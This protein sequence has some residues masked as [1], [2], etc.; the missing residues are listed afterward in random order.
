MATTTQS[1]TATLPPRITTALIDRLTGMVTAGA[2]GEKREPYEMIE[3]Y[4]GKVVGELPQSSPEDVAAAAANARAAQ[5]EWASWPLRRRLAVFERAHELILSEQETIADLIQIGSGKTRRMASEESCD[6]PMVISHYLKTA[7]RV[8]KPVRRGGPMPIISTSIEQHR[9]KGVVAVISPWNFP[10]AVSLSDSVPALIAGNGVVLK[11][12]N[13]TALCVLFGVELLYKAGLPRGL[14]QVV[15]G[16]GPDVGP[17]L[18]E[19]SDFVMFTGST[20]TG[21][22]LGELA[23]RHLIGCSL[24][25]GGKNPMIVLDDADL[26]EV[27][28]SAVFAVYGNTGQACMHIERIYVHDRVYDEFVRRFVADAEELGSKAGA[29][30]D[31]TP[32]FGSLVSV[33]QMQR[34]AS[35]VDDAVA[36]GAKVL[37]GGKPRPDLGPAFYEPTVLTDVTPDMVHA[38]L[39]TFGPVVT[40]YRF[41]DEQEAIR[42]ANAT[43][44]GLN[45]SVW[46]RNRAR[47]KKIADQLEAGNININD[48]YVATYSAKATPSGGVKESGV[49][50]RH[51]DAGLLKYTDTINIGIQKVQVLSAR[52]KM[53]IE[54]QLRTTLLTLRLMRRLRLR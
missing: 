39:E 20:A 23:G 38:T 35:H 21:R 16:T 49:G 29:T 7:K 52:A 46:S 11:P 17:S 28:P 24:E 37:T 18:V 50:N 12:D 36:K 43:T 51:G 33:E 47:A 10:F 40:V 34:V 54:K 3:V 8:L 9:P 26:D 48:G 41:S 6:V 1:G 5:K 19:N 45:A 44:Y 32:E 27:I 13:K 31:Y 53:P 2:A 42:K 15:C 4:T 14:V 25:L 30:Y 22:V